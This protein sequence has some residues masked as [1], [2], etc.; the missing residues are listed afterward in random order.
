VDYAVLEDHTRSQIK[1]DKDHRDLI[2]QLGALLLLDA[3]D[4]DEQ[5]LTP[6]GRTLDEAEWMNLTDELATEPA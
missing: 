6:R 5:A 3:A 2:A 1:P 4:L